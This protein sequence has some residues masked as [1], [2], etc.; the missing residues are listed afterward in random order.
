MGYLAFGKYVAPEYRAGVIPPVATRTGSPAAQGTSDIYFNVVLPAGMLPPGGWPI[1]IVGHGGDGSKENLTIDTTGRIAAALAQRRIATIGINI[2]GHGFGPL[3]TLTVN[4]SSGAPVTFTSGGRGVDQ[5]GDGVIGTREG[6]ESGSPANLLNDT[7][8]LRQTVADLMQLVRVIEVGVDIDGDGSPDLDPSRVYFVGQ[9]LGAMI[10]TDF[11]A[12]DPLVRAATLTGVG[13]P[14]T[15]TVLNAVGGRAGFGSIL[16]SRTPSLI[17]APGVVRL[18]GVALPLPPLFNENL[19]LR[20]DALLEVGLADGTTAYIQ[21]PVVNTVAGCDGHSGVSRTRG[22]GGADG[23]SRGVRSVSEE[24][25]VQRL[26]KPVIVQ[27]ATGDR[28]VP[29][30]A[31]TALLRAGDLADR[32]TYYRYDLASLQNPTLPKPAHGFMVNTP[33]FGDIARGAQ[34]QIAVFLASDAAMVIHPQPVRFFEV[35][36]AGS[37]PEALNFIG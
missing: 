33:A 7:D 32:A 31:T 23:K 2:A 1:A 11:V 27:F 21:S 35:P 4:R 5:N 25:S 28:F 9:S 17:N 15:S 10:G 6:L 8:G 30:P 37:L 16:A 36:I 18:D 22:M 13:G 14:R 3:G 34:E 19:P 24:S 26:E 29:N 12:L 20:D